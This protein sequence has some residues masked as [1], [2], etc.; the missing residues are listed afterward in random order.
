MDVDTLLTRQMELH[1]SI[2]NPPTTPDQV[3]QLRDNMRNFLI[4]FNKMREYSQK[5]NTEVDTLFQCYMFISVGGAVNFDAQGRDGAVPMHQAKVLTREAAIE[6]E[7][8][9]REAIPH[10]EL[11]VYV[12]LSR[13]IRTALRVKIEDGNDINSAELSVKTAVEYLNFIDSKA[14]G[15]KDL[16]FKFYMVEDEKTL[17]N[18]LEECGDEEFMATYRE[19]HPN[20][21]STAKEGG[22]ASPDDNFSLVPL[23]PQASFLKEVEAKS[24]VALCTTEKV[25]NRQR[26]AQAICQW[27]EDMPDQY[28]TSLGMNIMTA[29]AKMVTVFVREKRSA[30]CRV[31]CDIVSTVMQRITDQPFLSAE[32]NKPTS[33][34]AT[35]YGDWA[36]ALTKGVYVTVAAISLA[37]DKAMRELSIL[38]HG[39]P[40]VVKSLMMSLDSGSQTEL[41]RK[42]L[43][44][45]GLCVCAQERREKGSFAA[46]SKAV[47]EVAVKYVNVGDSPS[48][49]MA[50]A[51]CAVLES[52]TGSKVPITDEKAA[53]LI[54]LEK[55]KIM[56]AFKEG[57]RELECCLFDSNDFVSSMRP[58]LTSPSQVKAAANRSGKIGA[59]QPSDVKPPVVNH[60]DV[61]IP[62]L[63]ASLQQK[64]RRKP[65]Q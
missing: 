12:G 59:G 22:D 38:S 9:V 58:S 8:H 51:L 65:P 45:L 18:L 37:T 49:K 23:P 1:T 16:L 60:D 48:R 35:I 5:L 25:P 63:S 29:I 40:A 20:Y 11:M 39:H 55:Q 41:R 2:R 56:T 19:T 17:V 32:M 61:P 52:A 57:P 53:K 34:L 7:P 6:L 36:T 54:A 50:R 15:D 4:F 30:F 10:E 13:D 28:V 24:T 43:G 46:K 26:A 3:A 21:A 14:K 33:P 64:I 44:Y 47:T 62:K 27:L 31:G 42:C